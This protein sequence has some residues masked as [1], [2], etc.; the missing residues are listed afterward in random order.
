MFRVPSDPVNPTFDH[1]FKVGFWRWMGT[2]FSKAGADE[3][4]EWMRRRDVAARVAQQNQVQRFERYADE[5][6]A[7]RQRR[8]GEER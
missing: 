4:K 6:I 3:R 1:T 7:E 5:K 2:S 8:T